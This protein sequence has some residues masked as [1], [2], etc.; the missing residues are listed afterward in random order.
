MWQKWQQGKLLS[1]EE[2]HAKHVR[3]ATTK[4]HYIRLRTSQSAKF[5]WAA[6]NFHISCM[7][8]MWQM[9]LR[10]KNVTQK[11]FV[12]WC[13]RKP[14]KVFSNNWFQKNKRKPCQIYMLAKTFENFLTSNLHL[15]WKKHFQQRNKKRKEKAKSPTTK[16]QQLVCNN[17]QL[18]LF[19]TKKSHKS[20][21]S[22]V[23]PTHLAFRFFTKS[24][25]LCPL[26][27]TCNSLEKM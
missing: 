10:K 8:H 1:H 13:L 24:K 5:S 22:G 18:F 27:K 11:G 15:D 14:W 12:W 9:W 7:W 26:S 19:S 23:P 6:G 25:V 20:S 17:K 2:N 21:G 4:R 16:Q 3:E